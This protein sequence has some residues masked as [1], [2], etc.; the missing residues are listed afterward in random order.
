MIWSHHITIPG[1]RSWTK[2]KSV[3]A[4]AD[5]LC[6]EV[7]MIN[8]CSCLPKQQSKE[9][10]L[11]WMLSEMNVPNTLTRWNKGFLSNRQVAARLIF[12]QFTS[13][14]LRCLS[15]NKDISGCWPIF[16]E[17]PRRHIKQILPSLEDAILI[18]WTTQGAYRVD[19]TLYYSWG[20]VMTLH[21]S[22]CD[23]A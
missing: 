23:A 4:P 13:I 3:C 20:N 1:P 2:V 6:K 22:W 19:A 7:F 5:C 17:L 15:I 21:R 18:A 9:S 8:S 14:P 11:S 10:T 12:L 16:W